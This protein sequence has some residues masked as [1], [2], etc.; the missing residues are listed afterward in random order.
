MVNHSVYDRD[1]GAVNGLGQSMSSLAR[2]V[3]PALGGAL[4]SLSVKFDFIFL[5]FII[6]VA[7]LVLCQI[8]GRFLP[9][10]LDYSREEFD[11]LKLECK[12]VYDLADDEEEV[13]NL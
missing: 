1:L 12:G 2:S 7:I 6:A 13:V 3:G 4:W 5:N 10:S 8:L 9:V 11:I